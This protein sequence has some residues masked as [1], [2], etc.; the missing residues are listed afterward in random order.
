MQ[1]RHLPSSLHPVAPEAVFHTVLCCAVHVGRDSQ[2]LSSRPLSRAAYEPTSTT[3]AIAIATPSCTCLLL[4][5]R[6]IHISAT[7]YARLPSRPT[8]LNHSTAPSPPLPA[9][10]P[11]CILPLSTHTLHPNARLIG[12]GCLCNSLVRRNHRHVLSLW[13]KEQA[14]DERAPTCHSG[15]IVVEWSG[16]A[17]SSPQ[18][19]R[20]SRCREE[21]RGPTDSDADAWYEREQFA[22]LTPE[23]SKCHHARAQSLARAIGFKHSGASS[24]PPNLDYAIVGVMTF[25]Y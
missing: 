12:T 22:Q 2:R 11:V 13:Q 16:T 20:Q 18:W 19:G 4:A 17:T 1:H 3:I 5:L 21:S 15:D 23:C 8:R 25:R 24:M 7:R 10:I 6:P 14:T 9:P